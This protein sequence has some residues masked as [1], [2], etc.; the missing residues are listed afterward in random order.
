MNPLLDLN[1]KVLKVDETDKSRTFEVLIDGNRVG[2]IRQ[3]MTRLDGKV[4]PH[5]KF[6][7]D[8]EDSWA[9]HF[10]F[11]TAITCLVG[12]YLEKNLGKSDA[13]YRPS[14]SERLRRFDLRPG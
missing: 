10:S 2:T 11:S 7:V 6:R 8:S 3:G 4:T 5:S 9:N 1:L 14:L 12:I 13:R